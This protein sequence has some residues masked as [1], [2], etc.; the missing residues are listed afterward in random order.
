MRHG[1]NCWN[2]GINPG[3]RS[4]VHAAVISL[5]PPSIAMQ[6]TKRKVGVW[7]LVIGLIAL[8]LSAGCASTA[9]APIVYARAP[10]HATIMRPAPLPHRPAPPVD[11]PQPS[12]DEF[13]TPRVAYD[14][15]ASECVPFVRNASG[16]LI[17]GDAV[18]WW[19]QASGKYQRATLPSAGSVL[20]LRGYV[21]E[22]RGHV[23]H[24]KAIVSERM[25]R[26]DHA[27]W[28]NGGEV[29]LDVPVIDVSPLNDWSQVR[30]W[31]VPGMHWGGRIYEADGF[32]LPVS[33]DLLG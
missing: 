21:D 1:F 26:V 27:N 14:Q 32:I 17:W 16:I 8:S 20:V 23:A 11:L 30:V 25:I 31:H 10:G 19:R 6:R 33:L 5:D 9:P 13:T 18:T 15:P 4:R 22:T 7:A 3:S 28:L 2:S 24:V 12:Y 29:T